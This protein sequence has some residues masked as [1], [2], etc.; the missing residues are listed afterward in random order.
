MYYTGLKYRETSAT[1]P[2]GHDPLEAD[3]GAINLAT[4]R[5][6]GTAWPAHS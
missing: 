3:A 6:D 2:L 1:N 4:L 5:R